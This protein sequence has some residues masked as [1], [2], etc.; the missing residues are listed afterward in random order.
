MPSVTILPWEQSFIPNEKSRIIMEKP[1]LTQ[2]M[3]ASEIVDH[4]SLFEC[5][6]RRYH[7]LVVD[8]DV[9]NAVKAVM[10]TIK[11]ALDAGWGIEWM[12]KNELDENV[13]G[14]FRAT[15]SEYI[16]RP[17]FHIDDED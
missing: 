16:V 17:D 10:E 9:D 14:E 13:T 8:G 15:I 6:D 12:R 11:K 4:F 2:E 5:A 3:I 1:T 7:Y